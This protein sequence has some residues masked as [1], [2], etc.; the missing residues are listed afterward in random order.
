MVIL[1]WI[2]VAISPSD[3]SWSLSRSS[4]RGAFCSWWVFARVVSVDC[5]V[6]RLGF[7]PVVFSKAFAGFF[8]RGCSFSSFCRLG[9]HLAVFHFRQC[10]SDVMFTRF[11]FL[12]LSGFSM[13]S[14]SCPCSGSCII[15]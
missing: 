1:G 3:C 2:D 5:L 9:W 8:F 10:F 6:S 15:I 4:L 13:V 11:W 14:G 12:S 7:C